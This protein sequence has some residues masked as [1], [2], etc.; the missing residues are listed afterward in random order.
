MHPLGN[1][2]RIED[3]IGE[4]RAHGDVPAVPILLCGARRE[5][6]VKVFGKADAH[7]LRKTDGDINA[8]RKVA[9]DL[10]GIKQDQHKNVDAVELVRLLDQGFNTDHCGV[11]YNQLF[12][13]SPHH[14]EKSCAD[15]LTVEF[16]LTHKLVLQVSKTA[17]RP[18]Q[19]LWEERDEQKQLCEI[20]FSAHLFAVN[21][22]EVSHGLERIERNTKW[23]QKRRN[24][25]RFCVECRKDAIDVPYC[26][27]GIFQHCEH[28]KAE[29]KPYGQ[30]AKA[31]FLL[32]CAVSLA[33]LFG[34]CGAV[35]FD[36]GILAV[37]TLLH[38]ACD[39][40]GHGGGI[41][42]EDHTLPAREGIKADA[43]RKQYPPLRATRHEIVNDQRQRREEDE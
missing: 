29:D 27:G 35:F 37:C 13:I 7:R 15:V 5:R 18:L 20:F 43:C 32:F 39:K 12:E 26:K 24:G 19:Q 31:L 14:A 17:D 8:T 9:V 4:P 16:V 38:Q 42:N 2:E 3:V 33:L 36:K 40:V 34:E 30:N 11:G 1:R 23:Q 22:D 6:A 41:E 25:Q 28:S 21:V 10:C